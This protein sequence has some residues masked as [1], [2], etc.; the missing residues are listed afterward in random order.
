MPAVWSCLPVRGLPVKAR[1]SIKYPSVPEKPWESD[2][3]EIVLSGSF[4]LDVALDCLR[5]ML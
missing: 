5:E 1:S 2:L 3:L 4:Y